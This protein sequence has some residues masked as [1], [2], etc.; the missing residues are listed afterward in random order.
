MGQEF[1]RTRRVGEQIRRDLA[2]LLRDKLRD[3]PRMVMVSITLIEVSRDLA[4]AKVFI[5][6]LGESE[7]RKAIVDRLNQ[8]APMLRHE[9]G[10]QMHIRMVPKLKFL[11][12]DAI[13]RGAHLHSLISDAVAADAARHVHDEDDNGNESR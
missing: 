3:D 8:A 11:Y 10:R 5:T 4:H 2:Q 12:D 13:E 6:Y 1:S 9:L 7:E